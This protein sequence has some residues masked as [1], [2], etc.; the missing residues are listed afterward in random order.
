L[1]F[2]EV[3]LLSRIGQSAAVYYGKLRNGRA[4]VIRSIGPLL[5]RFVLGRM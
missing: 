2:F 3:P 5:K 1:N 4:L